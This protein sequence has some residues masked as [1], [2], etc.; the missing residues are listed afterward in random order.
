MFQ[1]NADEQNFCTV[2]APS[3]C[4]GQDILDPIL[5]FR[6][7]DH[8]RS[9]IV[10]FQCQIY[11]IIDD[12]Y[13]EGTTTTII[14]PTGEYSVSSEGITLIRPTGEYE[15]FS[16]AQKIEIALKPAGADDSWPVNTNAKIG[17]YIERSD[18]DDVASLYCPFLD[19]S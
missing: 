19:F 16:A 1:V 18:S 11:E 8:Y 13:A 9:Y 2:T 12:N 3:Q 4:Q 15:T 7:E 14:E 5:L 10:E 6:S 17:L